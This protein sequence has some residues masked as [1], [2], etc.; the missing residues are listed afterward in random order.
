M[1]T[2]LLNNLP[3]KIIS[4][5]AAIVLWLVVVNID[6]TVESDVFKN[7][8]VTLINTDT[9]TSQDQ[10]YRIEPGTDKVNVTV[11]ARRTELAKIKPSDFVV[12]A[13]MQKDL[14]YD[15]MVKIEVIYTGNATID[16]IE[17]SRE[18]VLVS[19][20]EKVTEEFKVT[21]DT[22]GNPSAGL[23]KGTVTPEKS[24]VEIS[25]PKSVI[26]Q[27]KKVVASVNI[28]GITGTS[29]LN[30]RLKLTNSDGVEIDDYS[31]LEYEWKDKDFSVTVTTLKTKV[32]GIS[33]DISKAAPEGYGVSS[34]S[35]KP[36]TVTIAGE[37]SDIRTIYNLDIPPEALNPDGKTGRVEQTVDISD[38]LPED[39]V[40]PEEDEHEIVVT[41]DIVALETM[42]YSFTPDQIE[43]TNI[44]DGLNVDLANSE[45]LILPVSGLASDLAGLTPDRIQIV[46]DLSD[47]TRAGN[48]TIPVTAVISDGSKFTCPD[49]VGI[50]V[51]VVS[52]DN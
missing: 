3:F 21:V 16:S 34:V 48:Y 35:Y 7:L 45:T 25:G 5:M 19:I 14:R 11:H 1:K 44:G 6:D 13:D 43:Y 40:I 41:M 29:V 20:E 32:V 50:T 17:Q 49:G 51:H 42:N 39:I 52:T 28:N 36:E 10:T 38:Y 37:Q 12:T 33:F 8:Q 23:D 22:T 46:A 27:V 18:N 24:L 9:I 15:S 2:K 30:C 26:A 4:V 47:V 31:Q